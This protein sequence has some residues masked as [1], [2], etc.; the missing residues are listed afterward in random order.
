M[1]T[2]WVLS[3]HQQEHCRRQVLCS[4]T[5]DASTAQRRKELISNRTERGSVQ[6]PAAWSEPQVY[7]LLLHEQILEFGK[8]V[9]AQDF[10]NKLIHSPSDHA[11]GTCFPRRPLPKPLLPCIHVPLSSSL[12]KIH[13]KDSVFQ[14]SKLFSDITSVRRK[15][16]K[17]TAKGK[18]K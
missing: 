8:R 9:L 17:Q 3:F 11:I 14:V 7:L 10:G 18:E 5:D 1:C 4:H 15:K 16:F 12:A 2:V 6:T 13:A